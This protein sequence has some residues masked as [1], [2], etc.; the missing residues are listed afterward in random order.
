[1][2]KFRLLRDKIDEY[3]ILSLDLETTSKIT[4]EAK[5]ELVA[6]ASGKGTATT[7]VAVPP[8]PEVLSFVKEQLRRP[9]LRIVGHNII[10]FD[11]EVLHFNGVF[12]LNDVEAKVID[13]LPLS[14]LYREMI[15]HGL[16]DMVNR[17][18]D[19]KMV[20][21]D[22]AYIHSPAM[23]M[24]RQSDKVIEDLEGRKS[25]IIT[26]IDKGARNE[27]K[28]LGN[29]LK[30]RFKGRRKKEDREERAAY[31][32]RINAYIERKFGTQVKSETIEAMDRKI[33]DLIADIVHLESEA[34]AQKREYAEDD[35]RQT[36]RLFY[37][38]RRYLTNRGI[39]R[40]ADMEIKTTFAAASMEVEGIHVDPDRL[41]KLEDIFVPLIDEFEAE[42]FNLAKMEFNPNSPQQVANVLYDIHGFTDYS[43]KRQTDEKNLMRIKHPLPQMIL[44]FK[45]LKK[46]HGTYVHKMRLKSRENRKHRIYAKFNPIGARKTGRASS[47][48][49]NLQNIPSRTKPQEYDERIQKLGPKIREAFCAP[50][51]KKIISAD[52]SQI[53]L[54]LIAH[55]TGD[56]NLMKIYQECVHHNGLVYYTGDVHES[57]RAFVSQ[58]VGFDISRKLAKNLNFGLCLV[59]GT[60]ILTIY[61]YRPIEEIEVGDLVMTRTGWRSVTALQ[62]LNTKTLVTVETST[63][64]TITGTPDHMLER[65][66]P[67]ANGMKGGKGWVEMGRLK[68]GDY[69]VY[70]GRGYSN[71]A[72]ASKESCALLGWFLSE[73]SYSNSRYKISQSPKVNP[74]VAKKMDEY[75][76]FKWYD[77]DGSPHISAPKCV[78]EKHLRRF[79]VEESVGKRI[80][81]SVFSLNRRARLEI[82][83]AMWDGDGSVSITGRRA[84]ITYA[85]KSRDLLND[86][87][88]LLDSVGIN[89]KV[90]DYNQDLSAAVGVVGQSS[91]I[92]F[93]ESVPTVKV[94]GKNYEPKKRFDAGEKITRVTINQVEPTPVYDFTVADDHSFIANGLVSHNCYGMMAAGFAVYAKL[95][96]AN[97]DYDVPGAD[98]FRN[99]FMTLYSG[100]PECMEYLDGLWD[101]GQRIFK[102]LSGRERHFTER[103]ISA[104]KLLNFIIQ[105]SAADILKIINWAIWEYVVKNRKFRGTKLIIQ[106]HDEISAEVPEKKATDVGI[107]IKYIMELAW[108][109][110]RVPT[111]ASAKICDAWSDKDNDDIPEIGHMPDPESGIIPCVAMLDD[112]QR[113][114]AA[115][116]IPKF[117][118]F[119]EIVE[120]A[121][122]SG[123]VSVDEF[124][125]GGGYG[126]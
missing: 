126:V 11:L 106:V 2:S 75:L 96:K 103:S 124:Y 102:T 12:D 54:R 123:F 78:F 69:L 56:A 66:F 35:A 27:I 63:G 65:Y 30:D 59:A 108:F 104:G 90:Y 48:G 80:P 32:V 21:Y 95:F 13:T 74:S 42:I 44:N 113:K 9:S 61:G 15:P 87:I 39:D 33:G 76:G 67:S 81:E 125:A 83:G 20:T 118:Q 77:L 117:D 17:I 14:W 93:L 38:L 82:L 58:M 22:E 98:R 10:R 57:T 94:V 62:R 28:R 23:M 60:Q 116:F 53:E 111:F 43:G 5:I 84:Q 18:F 79:G 37:F 19:Y 64:K 49:P 88:R 89:S 8:T 55:V 71:G 3:G 4:R 119:D 91:K 73:G 47:S 24:I 6:M 50:P 72:K 120:V 16:K 46:L 7:T 45:S 36:L 51:G 109:N 34:D 101:D 112:D 92:R 107:L 31:Q 122:S 115:K 1:M 85:S 99:A 25:Q 100:I 97:G 70:H 110:L 114:W 26:E 52:L 121:E 29:E 105:G 40:W 41:Q 68:S 86:V